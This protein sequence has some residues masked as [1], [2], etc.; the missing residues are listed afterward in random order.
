MTLAEVEEAHIRK[1]LRKTYYNQSA[2]AR[3]L[4]VDRKLLSRKVKKYDIRAPVRRNVRR[5]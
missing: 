2:A 1:T 4:G 3:L 5:E